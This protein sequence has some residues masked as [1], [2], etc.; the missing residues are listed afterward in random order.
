ME[1]EE[2]QLYGIWYKSGG[3][4]RGAQ[5]TMIQD[6]EVEQDPFHYSMT[7]MWDDDS[8]L[9]DEDES[10][11]TALFILLIGDDATPNYVISSALAVGALTCSMMF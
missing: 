5:E 1:Y 4:A 8:K 6:T 2:T 7:W 9:S 3:S 11:L 10:I